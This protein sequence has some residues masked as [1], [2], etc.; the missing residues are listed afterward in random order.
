ME[1]EKAIAL[2]LAGTALATSP[3][4][5]QEVGTAAAVNPESQSSAAR[6]RDHHAQGRRPGRAQGAHQDHAAGIRTASLS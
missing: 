4:F 2:L 3:V 1:W 5:A 6:R